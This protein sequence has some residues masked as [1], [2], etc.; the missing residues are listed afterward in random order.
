M[1][2]VER[3][4][5]A[6][7]Q[8]EKKEKVEK[9]QEKDLM[10]IPSKSKIEFFKRKSLQTIYESRYE[11]KL[12]PLILI[13]SHIRSWL[14]RKKYIKIRKAAI[15][16]QSYIKMRTTKELYKHILQA[17][18]FIQAMYRGHRVRKLYNF[19]LNPC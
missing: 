14:V 3:L 8:H 1:K 13:Q 10:P 15:T 7:I 18:I 12:E 5:N 9:E 19:L 4:K 16:L 11:D 17:A 2:E 6:K